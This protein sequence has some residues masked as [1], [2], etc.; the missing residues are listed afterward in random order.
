MSAKCFTLKELSEMVF[1]DI[2]NT[3]DKM[4]EVDSDVERHLTVCQCTEVTHCTSYVIGLCRKASTVQ[5]TL[6]KF[7]IRK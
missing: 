7:F 6:D 4:L 1:H 5:V 2:E 3:K